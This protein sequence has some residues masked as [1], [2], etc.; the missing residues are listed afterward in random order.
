V[1]RSTR[2]PVAI[3]PLLALAS[4]PAVAAPDVARSPEG[5]TVRGAPTH[6][7]SERASWALAID[8]ALSKP[9][10]EQW[11]GPEVAEAWLDI[12][13]Q[14]RGNM[15]FTRDSYDE[16]ML[17]ALGVPPVPAMNYEPS[18]GV[19]FVAMDGVTIRPNCGN[20]D[21]ANSALD[22]SPL[23]SAETTFDAF[24]G[25]AA[26]EFQTLAS[27]YEDFDIVMT[28][29][30]PPDWLPYTMTVI[31]GSASQ[32]GVAGACGI[33]N[34]ACDGLKRNHVSLNF[35]QSCNGM[36]E[37][38]AQETSHNWGLEHT[39]NPTDLL[40]P[41]NNGGFKTFVDECMPI[42]NATGDGIT[43]CGYIHELYC[44]EGLGEEQNS[45]QELMGVFG[46]RTPDTTPPEIVSVSPADGSV[47]G[48][49]ED[50]LITA[51]ISENSRM[52]GVNWSWSE[53]LPDGTESYRRCTNN[54]CDQDFNPGVSFLA[55]DMPWDFVV[56][57]GAPAGTYTFTVEALDAYG[58][59]ASETITIEVVEGS[60]ESADGG[61]DESDGGSEAGETGVDDVGDGT[62]GTPP[63]DGGS[64]EGTGDD[65]GQDGDGGTSSDG[66]C[67]IATPDGS[68]LALLGLL[69]LRRRRT[70]A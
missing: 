56:L 46:P 54:V 5:V 18:P 57:S 47:L 43:Q 11:Y 50:I 48:N 3:L 51:Q 61:L 39:D 19:M 14:W 68:W 30:R 23:V 31:G 9:T 25:G 36:A 13:P 45:Y 4:V 52:V 67:R 7:I 40:Y 49:D 41:F 28:S 60:G 29:N 66:G 58:N 15:L 16:D 32:I 37:T 38:A 27:Y 20:G 17:A 22:C 12:E 64:E 10:V 55:E 24:G 26:S 34:V 8:D 44:P 53:G 65:G 62:T 33:A 59:Y 2:M 63:G 70:R 1:T 69:A 6:A 21:T 35:P 42:S